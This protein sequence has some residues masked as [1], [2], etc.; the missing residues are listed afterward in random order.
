MKNVFVLLILTIVVCSFSMFCVRSNNVEK[1]VSCFVNNKSNLVNDS[2]KCSGIYNDL[3]YLNNY[4]DLGKGVVNPVDF[5]FTLILDTISMDSVRINNIEEPN[6]LRPI[7]YKPDYLIFFLVVR[8]TYGRYYLIN[9]NENQFGF[10]RKSEFDFFTWKDLFLNKSNSLIIKNG[11]VKRESNTLPVEFSNEDYFICLEFDN[12][13]L[14]VEEENNPHNKY[15][16]KWKT[17]DG[18]DVEPVFLD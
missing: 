9:I 8:N 10:V 12:D 14:Y 15:W 16:V 5:S 18:L 13:W 3:E 7:F 4:S 1:Y 11:Y 2:K 17:D 6:V